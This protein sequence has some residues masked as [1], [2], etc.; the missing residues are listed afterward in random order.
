MLLWF[1][2]VNGRDGE[3]AM[4]RKVDLGVDPRFRVRAAGSLKQKAGCPESTS[5]GLDPERLEKLCRG[6]CYNPGDERYRIER[7]EVVRIRPQKRPGEPVEDLIEDPWRVF[8]CSA[9]DD[10]GCVV[11]FTDPEYRMSG[12]DTTYYVRVIQ[13]AQPRVNGGHM[14]CEYDE[15][16]LCIKARPCYGDYRTP[17]DDACL[18]PAAERAWSSPIYLT[19]DR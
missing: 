10:E 15:Q 11:E 12:R 13:E 16:G 8:D 7:V 5:A 1:D 19:Y 3:V 18:E 17:K 9:G 14:R 6:E 4:G 2:L